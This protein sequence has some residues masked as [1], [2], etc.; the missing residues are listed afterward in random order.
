MKVEI[1]LPKTVEC[2]D[3]HEFDDLEKK[4]QVLHPNIRCE[5]IGL[6]KRPAP[7]TTY[8]GM[9]YLESKRPAKRTIDRMKTK[10]QLKA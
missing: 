9:I 5:E 10:A 4:L 2:V 7:H 8:L 3:Y 6:V 1:T